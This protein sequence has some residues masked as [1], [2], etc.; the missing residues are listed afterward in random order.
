MLA[1]V[2]RAS[3]LIVALAA[4]AA[5]AGGTG[6]GAL[7]AA[8]HSGLAGRVVE[9]PTCPVQRIP[10][11]PGCNPRGLQA[12]LRIRRVAAHARPRTVHADRDGRF[13]LSLAPGVYTVQGLPLAKAPLPRPPAPARVR[14]RAGHT[15]TITITYDSGIR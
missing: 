2:R 9:A 7:A 10:P 6:T 12:T 1:S 4:L 15:T 3:V 13:H 5:L 11:Q 14:I 8:P